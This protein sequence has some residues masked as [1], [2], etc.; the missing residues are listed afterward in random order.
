MNPSAASCDLCGLSL[1][2]GTVKWTSGN[3][4]FSFCCMGCRQVFI[5]LIEAADSPDPVPFKETELFKKC[6]EMGIIP[7]S[8]SDLKDRLSK[9][10]ANSLFA[11]PLPDAEP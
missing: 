3:R 6:R 5:M 9:D 8:E 2:H 7:E 1:R 4:E 11:S 10:A